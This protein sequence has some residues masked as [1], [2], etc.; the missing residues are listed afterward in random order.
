MV[1]KDATGEDREVILDQTMEDTTFKVAV[2]DADETGQPSKYWSFRDSSQF[3]AEEETRPT[4]S[5]GETEINE[6]NKKENSTD[7]DDK[8]NV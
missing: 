7:S 4:A 6:Q 5:S 3:E 2:E 1:S 8:E